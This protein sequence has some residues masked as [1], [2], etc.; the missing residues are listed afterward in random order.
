MALQQPNQSYDEIITKSRE[1]L[2][3]LITNT[4]CLLEN[5]VNHKYF[6]PEDSENVMQASTIKERVRKIIDLV[7]SKKGEVAEFFIY[8][9]YK[10]PE[11]YYDLDSWLTEIDFHPSELIQSLPITNNDPVTLYSKKLKQVLCN[12][13]T[14]V[15]SYSQRGELVLPETYVN[16][17][18]ELVSDKN[19]NMGRVNDLSS[20]FDDTGVINEEGETTFIYGDAGM[21]KTLLIQKLQNMWAKGESYSDTRF[22]FSFSFRRFVLSN[23][24]TQLSLKDLLFRYNCHPDNDPEEVFHYI[25]RF[26]ETVMFTFDGFDE[27]QSSFDLNNIPEVSLPTDTAHPA[28][29]LIHLLS[30]KLLK[31][32]RKV[33]TAR[34]GCQVSGK[35]VRKRIMLRG[36]GTENLM[37]YTNLFFRDPSVQMHVINQLEAN[38]NISSLC[39]IPLFCWII[40]KSF[41]HFHSINESHTFSSSSVTLTDIFLLI[42]EVYLNSS[43][44]GTTRSQAETYKKGRE[45]LLFIGKLAYSGMDNSAF[46]F[47]YDTITS[48]NIP[49]QYLQLGFFRTVKNYDGCGGNSSFEFF[50]VILQSFFTA[51]FLVIDS[52]TSTTELLKYFSHCAY[53]PQQ[54]LLPKLMMSVCAKKHKQVDPFANNDHLQFINLF[55][56]GLLSKPKQVLLEHLVPPS[57]LK[58]KRKAL[59]QQLFKS[60]KFHLKH[61]PR[62]LFMGYN[63]VHALTHFIWMARCVCE[64]QCEK[65]GKYVAKGICADYIKLSFCGASSSDCGAISFLLNQ[66]QKEIALELDNNNINDYGVKE[67]IPCF[68]KLTVVRLSVNQITDEGVRILAE[69]LT[70]YKII[71]YLGLYKN[72]I[73]D[74]GAKHVAQIILGCPLL[75]QL[76]LGYNQFT[77]VGG[78]EIAEALQRNTSLCEVGMWGNHIGDEGAQAFAEAIRNHSCLEVLSLACNEITSVGGKYLADA[79]QHNT[80]IKTLWLTENSITDEAT[81]SFAEML[82]VNKTLKQLWLNQ[83][84]ITNYGANILAEALGYNTNIEEICL[85]K[86][87]LNLDKKEPFQMDSRIR[88]RT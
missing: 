48:L 79:L 23:A 14:F 78:R 15:P 61:L 42:I 35:L 30:G 39:S 74:N 68:R 75:Q 55:L 28:A 46:L 52:G 16:S 86:N 17:A 29:L 32:S 76:K 40:F 49:E 20:L 4:Q 22:F 82:K 13:S 53:S 83:N 56:C 25:L 88:I 87:L 8:V 71:I 50:H 26:P 63:C 19:E 12:D 31:R 24:N 18:M 58:V 36:F 33:L 51:L 6:S 69:E 3:N 11:A 65:V 57:V 81:K 44:R 41:E 2:V 84:H 37:E 70:K 34:T 27:M 60:V 77:G 43:N 54:E 62:S 80:S 38:H 5:L 64:T 59:K 72:L 1:I 85:Q 45:T 66:Y 10:I 47:D 7:E 67:L 21:G 9:L 73:T